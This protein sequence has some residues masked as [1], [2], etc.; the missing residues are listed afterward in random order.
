MS[1][2]CD[3]MGYEVQKK[4]K[5]LSRMKLSTIEAAGPTNEQTNK[6]KR[7]REKRAK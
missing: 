2:T 4:H 6:N 3:K 7:N 1:K 5:K